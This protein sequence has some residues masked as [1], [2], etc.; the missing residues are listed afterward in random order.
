MFQALSWKLISAMSTELEFEQKA[1][2][3]HAHW[4]LCPTFLKIILNDFLL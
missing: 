2:K 1:N 4:H 3:F